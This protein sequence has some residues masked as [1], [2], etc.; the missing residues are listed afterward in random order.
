MGRLFGTDGVRGV[1][2]GP[3]TP[4][5]ALALGRSAGAAL[6]GAGLAGAD[7]PRRVAIGR[8]TRRSGPML[9]SA[10]AAGFASAGFEVVDLGVVPTPALSHAVRGGGFAAGV[11]VSASHNPAPDNGIKLFG[12]DGRKLADELEAAIEAGLADEGERPTGGDLGEIRSDRSAVHAYEAALRGIVPGG[13]AGMRIAVDA[14]NGAAYHLAPGVLRALGADVVLAHAEPDGMN[15]NAGCGATHPETIQALTRESGADVG[16]AFDGDADRAVFSDGRG[17]L[18]NGDRTLAIWAAERLAAGRLDPPVVVGT[19]MSNGGFEAYLDSLGV[20]LER[21]PVGDKHVS[22]RIAA[23]GAKAGGEQSGHVVF[24]EHG[25]TGDGIATAL[26]LFGA[27]RAS[28][29]SLEELYERFEN[30]PQL[31]VNVTVADR[32][33]WGDGEGVREALAR[34]ERDLAGRGRINVR[35]SGTQ[36]MIRV[37]VEA[38]DEGFRDL[39]AASVVGAL[40]SEAGGRVY[41]RVDLTHSLGE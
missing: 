28:G 33:T 39:V 15:I 21:T 16:V 18:V 12:A 7:L 10:C 41:S 30:W 34:A 40:A 25:P 27:I 6:R 19:V 36:P 22:A 14:A 2:N 5:L 11:V 37:M 17:R 35:A 31:L 38:D 13:L 32:A 9:L 24:P 26:E 3:L 8:D 20:R 1:A 23:T 29:R 4:E